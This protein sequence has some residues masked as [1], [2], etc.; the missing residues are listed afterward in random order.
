MSSQRDL[1]LAMDGMRVQVRGLDDTL[2]AIRRAG[3]GSEDMREL[4]HSIGSVVAGTARTLAPVGA[5]GRLSGSI[6]AGRGKTK[7]VVRAGG[8]RAPYSGVR[9]YGAPLGAT[10]VLGRVINADPSLFLVQA[11][12][13]NRTRVASMVEQGISDLLRKHALV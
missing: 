9:H 12:D 8:A 13:Q 1:N 4:M 7:A 6:R 2:K 10:D 3:E 11:I 5:S